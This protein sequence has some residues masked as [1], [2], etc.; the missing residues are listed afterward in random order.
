MVGKRASGS[1]GEWDETLGA[2]RRWLGP[3]RSTCPSISL[4]HH[5]VPAVTARRE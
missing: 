3:A 5:R 4:N 2:G 1:V